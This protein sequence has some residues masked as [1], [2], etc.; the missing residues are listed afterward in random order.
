[1]KRVE[2]GGE[3]LQATLEEGVWIVEID[4]ADEGDGGENIREFAACPC[5]FFESFCDAVDVET[6]AELLNEV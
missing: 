1:M 6:L 2:F 4:D 3:N 5:G